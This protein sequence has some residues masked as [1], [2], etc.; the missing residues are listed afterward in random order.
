M[1]VVSKREFR[2]PKEFGGRQYMKIN[3]SAKNDKFSINLPEV[4][5]GA[6]KTPSI[7]DQTLQGV[8]KKFTEAITEF[9][10]KKTVKVKVILL[11]VETPYDHEGGEYIFR[12]RDSAHITFDFLPVFEYRFGS[13]PTYM[14]ILST[15]EDGEEC[16]A[17]DTIVIPWTADNEQKLFQIKNSFRI[18]ADLIEKL[19]GPVLDKET[20]WGRKKDNQKTVKKILNSLNGVEWKKLTVGGS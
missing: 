1:P 19:I 4:M 12:Q 11:W 9:E 8:V 18:Y 20:T 15:G 3:F 2:L 6:L 14:T 16:E 13:N 7:S 10:G 5:A 17:Y